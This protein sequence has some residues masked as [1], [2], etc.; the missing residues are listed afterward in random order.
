M[1][2]T[3][4]IAVITGAAQGIGKRVGERHHPGLGHIVFLLP[5]ARAMWRE[6]L[7]V[8][9]K[10]GCDHAKIRSDLLVAQEMT[11]LAPV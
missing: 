11:V 5:P 4:R 9:R 8:I 2:K 10:V 6:R 3:G 1:I 7:S